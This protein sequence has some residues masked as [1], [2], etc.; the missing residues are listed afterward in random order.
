MTKETVLI[1]GGAG[2]IGSHLVDRL[3]KEGYV[4]VVFDDFSLGKEENLAQHKNNKNLVIYRK[5]IGDDLS[6]IFSKHSFRVVFHLG[7]IPSVQFSLQ[8]PQKTNAIN[9]GG[10]LNLLEHCRK[11]KLKRFILSSSSAV[12]G[13][14]NIL[15]IK[16]TAHLRPLSPY[17]LQKLMSEQYCHLYHVVYGLETISLRYF[18]VFGPRQNPKGDYASLIPKFI[19][20]VSEGKSP[21]I[22]GD[23]TQTR[24]FV[25]VSDVV[26]AN[27]LAAKTNN[28]VC[29]GEAFNIGTEKNISVNKIASLI[30]S[31]A[32]KKVKP[33]YGPSLI[34]PKNTQADITKAE[35]M[36]D[37]KPKISFEEG[38]KYMFNYV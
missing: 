34:E 3:L 15:P 20:Q 10:T 7:A 13:M 38:L 36:L 26:E 16:E 32:Q 25:F 21:T 17:G 4:V 14:Q 37:W 1:T 5:S 18:N 22:N 6:E 9:L 8:E 35:K 11:F 12:Y 31:L 23:G 30:I 24:D 19:Q 33:L 2:F 29:F 28:K 27:L